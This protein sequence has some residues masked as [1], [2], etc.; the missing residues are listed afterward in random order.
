MKL[1]PSPRAGRAREGFRIDLESRLNSHG[2]RRR[3]VEFIAEY[4]IS[5]YTEVL[6][7]E[8][9]PPGEPLLIIA[10]EKTVSTSRIKIIQG[11]VPIDIILGGRTS[12]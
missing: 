11:Y 6:I 1:A 10:V 7:W 12:R 3:F 4:Y 9:E 2:F 5:V 8:G